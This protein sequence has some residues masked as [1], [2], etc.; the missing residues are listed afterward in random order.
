MNYVSTSGL[1]GGQAIL[2]D[3]LKKEGDCDDTQAT[4]SPEGVE[5]INQS[6][7]DCDGIIDEE[8]VFID[9]METV[10][11]GQEGDC[12]DANGDVYRR[13]RSGE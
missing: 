9:M 12:D 7:D 3:T 13:R 4:I 8:T 5:I 10:F 11:Q 1:A 2:M 6:D